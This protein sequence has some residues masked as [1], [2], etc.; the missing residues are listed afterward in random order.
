MKILRIIKR[1]LIDLLAI[2]NDCLLCNQFTEQGNDLICTVCSADI[3]SFPPTQNLLS[4]LHI[5]D[6]YPEFID[7]LYAFCSYQTPVSKWILG[8]KFNNIRLYA[9]PLGKLLNNSLQELDLGAYDY[10]VIMP[11]NRLRERYRGYNQVQLI[12]RHSEVLNSIPLLK[13]VSRNRAT[14]PQSELNRKQRLRNV[15]NAFDV[16][17]DLSSKAVLIVDDVISTGATVNQMAKA[18]KQNGAT[19]VTAIAVCLNVY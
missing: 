11:L 19:K 4:K 15:T 3:I 5:N 13:C 7:E 16:N 6:N 9:K 8:L 17:T 10:C 1:I 2:K 14:R 12:H 18:L